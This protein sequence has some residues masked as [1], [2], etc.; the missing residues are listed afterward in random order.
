[1]FWSDSGTSAGLLDSIADTCTP[2]QPAHGVPA[3]GIHGRVF[4][5]AQTFR[6]QLAELGLTI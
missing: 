2:Q 4:T 3:L 1:M 6:T 5:D